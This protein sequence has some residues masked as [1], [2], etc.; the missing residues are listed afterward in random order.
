MRMALAERQARELQLIVEAAVSGSQPHTAD[1]LRT[2]F[3]VSPATIYND[4]DVLA[5]LRI[6]RNRGVVEA[7]TE[8]DAKSFPERFAAGAALKRA[9]AEFV[10][11]ECIAPGS[12]V[13]IDTGSTCYQV[14]NV[15]VD[16]LRDDIRV[17]TANPYALHAFV[18]SGFPGEVIVLGG[19]LRRQAA[20][21][22]G[23]L[24]VDALSRLKCDVAIISVDFVHDDPEGTFAIFSDAELEQK[25]VAIAQA[26]SV[27]VVADEA[28]LGRNVGN[29]ISSFGAVLQSKAVRL[30]IGVE[31]GSRDVN[32]KLSALRG[33]LGPSGVSA[34]TVA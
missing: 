28:K 17:L 24:T 14:A 26:S 27:I 25:R 16:D 20:S 13:F 4:L 15:L 5:R 23:T 30:V 12:I 31:T 8:D 22:H 18:D 2:A 34:V 7:R 32:A 33:I 19:I 10:V 9:I 21:L 29:A 1:S 11:R 6:S 3:N